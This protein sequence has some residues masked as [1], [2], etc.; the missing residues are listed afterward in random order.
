MRCITFLSAALRKL[1]IQITNDW[2]SPHGP[3]ELEIMEENARFSRLVSATCIFL[4][5][6]TFAAQFIIAVLRIDAQNR[7][8]ANGT[9]IDRPLYM[10]ASF[11]YDSQISPNYE[12][13][14]AG[15]LFSNF[16]AAT[17]YTSIDSLFIVL[18][19][20]LCGQLS[21]LRL[22][23]PGLKGCSGNEFAEKIAYIHRRHDQLTVCANTIEEVFNKTFLLQIIT[24]S[25]VLCMLGYQ[26]MTIT[27]GN[28]IPFMELVFMIYYVIC[29]LFI[30]FTYC[31]M[32]EKLREKSVDISDAAYQCDWY[33]LTPQ[34]SKQLIIIMLRARRPLQVTA[35]KFVAF[36][37][38]LYCSILKSSGGYMSMLLAIQ[39]RLGTS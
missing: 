17:T 15:Q 7:L 16:F 32:A 36:S 10:R 14:L 38:S 23:F 33:D 30:T 1:M 21:V 18:M 26:I 2:R 39:Q 13:T 5:D 12:L 25:F 22:K 37:L 24:S 28:N 19:L 11:P 27:N 20:H 29:F 4:A 3:I 31:Y 9:D 8:Q 34:Q 35:G 6:A